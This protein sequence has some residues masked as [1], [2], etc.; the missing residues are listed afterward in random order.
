MK[1]SVALCHWISAS[2]SAF[3]KF[4]AR[5]FTNRNLKASVLTMSAV[6]RCINTSRFILKDDHFCYSY[7]GPSFQLIS[8]G[9]WIFVE[10]QL[11]RLED[12][13]DFTIAE[14]IHE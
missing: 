10:K 8:L 14:K 1:G 2:D 3:V 4:H 7:Y 13:A 5:L 6:K 12:G 11:K 9:K